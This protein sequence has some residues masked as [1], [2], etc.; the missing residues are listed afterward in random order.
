V[1]RPPHT[2][3]VAVVGSSE[4]DARQV[5]LEKTFE[6]VMER[7]LSQKIDPMGWHADVLNFGVPGY[8]YSQEYLTLRNHV[9]KYEPQIVILL[10]SGFPVLKT[11]REF[12]PAELN[13]APVYVLQADGELVPD[14]ITRNTPH[15][16]P[17]R[18]LWKNRLS[19]WMNRSYLLSLLN[20]ALKKVPAIIEQLRGSAKPALA[21]STGVG[22]N[23]VYDPAQPRVHQ[24]WVITEAFLKEMK[25]DCDRHGAEF[26]LVVAD[27]A[28][29]VHPSLEE[30]AEF[31]RRMKLSSLDLVDRH[32]ERF[33]LSQGIPVFALAPDLGE[34]AAAHNAILHGPLGSRENSG[35]WNEVGNELAGHAIAGE[36]VARSRALHL[37]DPH[38]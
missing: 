7:D 34:Y 16:D 1:V 3:R 20:I 36:L 23:W 2:L 14:A 18:L 5:P 29:Q 22:E 10:F 26:W 37:I 15:I 30:R 31:Q 25:T 21:L 27:T 24:S 33:G 12:Y 28:V 6:A 4:V 38:P 11:T 13:G 17:R 9:W 32:V 35:H 19:D 8:T